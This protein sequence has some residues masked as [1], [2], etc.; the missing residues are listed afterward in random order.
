MTKKD[1][2]KLIHDLIDD[3]DGEMDADGNPIK[4]PTHEQLDDLVTEIY[5]LVEK[6]LG[7]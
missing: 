3:A 6:E 5:A 7:L 4:P 1:V 2:L